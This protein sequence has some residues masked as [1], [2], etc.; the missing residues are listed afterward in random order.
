MIK[1]AML[2]L[3]VLQLIGNTAAYAVGHTDVYSPEELLAR[4]SLEEKFGQVLLMDIREWLTEESKAVQQ[5][6]IDREKSEAGGTKAENAELA[7]K[8]P[9]PEGLTMLNDEVR[10]LIDRYRLGNIILFGE[11]C[12][13]TAALVR[14]TNDLQETA[15]ASG[16]L[17]MLITVDQE[18][19]SITRLGG[20]TCMSGN[21]AIGASGD[22]NNAYLNGKVIGS[23]LKAVGIS[24]DFAPVA[25]VNINPRN[26]VIGIRSFSDDPLVA[27]EMAA[28]MAQGLR[29]EGIIPCAK[30][31][32]GHGNTETDSHTGFPLITTD[33]EAWFEGEGVSFRYLIENKAV[34]MIMSAHIQYPGL[35]DTRV[36]SEMDGM[37]IYLPA[38]LSRHILTD[39]LKGELGFDGVIVTDSMVMDAIA[40]NFD[41]VEAVIMALNA[42][43]DLICT[44]VKV[45]SKD[46][47]CKMDALYTA[48]RTALET[49][50]LSMERL[51]DAVLRVL[52]LKADF[53]LI[54]V[55]EDV[56]F[57][58]K[59][60]NAME[61][62]G[63][64]ENRAIERQI[65]ADCVRMEYDGTF[66][67][68]VPNP[69]DQIAVL[70]PYANEGNSVRF[71]VQ[72]L[73]RE[74]KIPHVELNIICYQ[75]EKTPS[76]E[77]V[78]AI[79]EADWTILIS[80]QLNYV[81]ADND[82]WLTLYPVRALKSAEKSHTVILC[83]GLPYQSARYHAEWPCFVLYNYTGM[84]ETDV[85]AE[86]FTGKF[87][88]AIPAAVEKVFGQ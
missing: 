82:L 16:L 72:R 36:I 23:E 8:K 61:V 78:Q 88:P 20:G 3:L 48:L 22:R 42:G 11:N 49:E 39:I 6:Q 58:R 86:R 18:G 14:L 70:V 32:P 50:R 40:K 80:E 31:F 47:M 87:G 62:V 26:P 55:S 68:L 4:M 71:A 52:T 41:S 67:P 69:G 60:A 37:E 51:N 85:N 73:E 9:Q 45:Q 1:K 84:A 38:T 10:Q 24:A 76:D 2:F 53:G 83:T 43:A 44:P 64:A 34:P 19:G 5:A 74:G 81:E 30:H 21:M 75:N 25:D 54:N 7:E 56:P 29:D 57:D 17:P 35:D 46:D 59:V 66:T 12:K 28:A 77:A 65:A 63:G 79:R 15:K 27:G 33:K 13:E